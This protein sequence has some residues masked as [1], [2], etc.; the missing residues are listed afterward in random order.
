MADKQYKTE[1]SFSFEKVGASLDNMMSSLRE[2]A[3]VKMA[4]FS[5]DKEGVTSADINLHFGIGQMTLKPLTASDNLFEADVTYVGEIE[6]TAD[7][8]AHRVVTLKQKSST[9]A[10]VKSIKRA[11]GSFGKRNDLRWDV[12]ISP[13]VPLALKLNTGVG[14]Q[15]CDLRGMKLTALSVNGGTGE[16]RMTLPESADGY[17]ADFNVGVGETTIKLPQNTAMNLRV[18]AGVGEVKIHVPANTAVAVRARGGL[19]D[20]SVPS[21]FVR[22]EGKKDFITNSGVW[23]TPNFENAER[24]VNIEY[25]GGVGSFRIISDVQMV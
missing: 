5:E 25:N 17:D 23:Q 19:G 12:R 7:G 13:D 11:I 14:E 18:R 21:H 20:T 10:V 22:I 24:Q 16:T 6:F 4:S 2:D 1:W 15:D 3:E 9:E 8:E